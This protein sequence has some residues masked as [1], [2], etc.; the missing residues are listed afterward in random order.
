MI[1][2]NIPIHAKLPSV[3]CVPTF[4]GKDTKARIGGAVLRQRN[5]HLIGLPTG[6]LQKAAAIGTG[7]YNGFCAI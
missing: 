4:H 1:A 3:P 5:G 7:A 2:L 6:Q